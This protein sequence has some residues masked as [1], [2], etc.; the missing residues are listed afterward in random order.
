M[1]T[2]RLWIVASILLTAACASVSITGR[3]Q[4]NLVSDR[5]LAAAADREFARLMDLVSQKNAV[6]A[7]TE[8]PQAA[9]V[10][11]MVQRVADRVIDA[12]GL[13]GHYAWETVVVKAREANAFALPNGKVV[14]FTGLLSVTQTE[15]A[16]AAVISH[17]VAHVVARHQA[18]RLSQFVLAQ[19]ALTTVDAVLAAKNSQ[20]R[21]IIGAAMGLGVQYGVLL[22]FGRLHESEA[23]HMGLFYMAKAGYDPAEAVGLWERMETQSGTGPWELLS[24]HPSNATR[25]EQ[26]RQWL[27]EVAPFYADPT[28]P[29]PSNLAEAQA[30]SAELRASLGPEA[31]RPSVQAGYWFRSKLSNRSNVTTVRFGGREPCAGGEC[32]SLIGDD[33]TT[34][35][36]VDFGW[37]ETKHANG[38]W[39]RFDPPLRLMQWPLRVGSSW[40]DT[41]EA[42][43]SSGTKQRLRYKGDVVA[44]EVVRVPGG[45]FMAFKIVLTFNGIRFRE[46]WWAPETRTSVRSVVYDDRGRAMTTAELVD[47]Q[48]SD[49]PSGALEAASQGEPPSRD[50]MSAPRQAAREAPAI[51]HDSH[52]PSSAATLP[53]SSTGSQGLEPVRPSR[54]LT[55]TILSRSNAG[56][57]LGEISVLNQL[58]MDVVVTLHTSRAATSDVSF[59]VRAGEK[60]VITD[61]VEG[62]YKLAYTMGEGWT[63][64]QFARSSG[65]VRLDQPLTF[66]DSSI[67]V[68]GPAGATVR[69]IPGDPWDV[70]LRPSPAVSK[71]APE[72]APSRSAPKR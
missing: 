63:E 60:A 67:V 34:T 48:K 31:V 4:L 43:S 19:L 71:G 37:V 47:Y 42:A 66:Q 56:R 62:E 49:E 7:R 41:T 39:L 54:P 28:R 26:I 24:S 6:L 17:E 44:Y 58:N 18:E 3:S 33:G 45:S 65:T 72:M 70:V 32:F 46:T 30:A 64:G 55:G 9:T 38:T 25:R 61:I 22:P 51:P 40:S 36:T 29:L 13:R 10:L 8:S 68:R 23:D 27:S 35:Y 15:A 57:G 14:V 50:E 53:P 20:Y 11:D 1:Q 16:L 59:Y 12:A 69:S 52:P 21:P 5:E 2:R